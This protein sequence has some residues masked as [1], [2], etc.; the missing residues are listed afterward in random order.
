M[1]RASSGKLAGVYTRVSTD[2]QI[3]GTSLDTQEAACRQAGARA[4]FKLLPEY[5]V[6]EQHSGGTLRRPGLESLRDWVQ[7]RLV[8]AVVFYSIDRLSR[9]AVDL[10]ILLREFK[11]HGVDVLAVQ[12]TPED[13]P[14][15]RA[16]TFL[17]GT[18]AELE[19]REIAERT[20]RGKLARAR[21]GRL[22]QGTGKGLYGYIYDSGTKTRRVNE[23]EARIARQVFD[24]AIEGL[25]INGIAR[26]L[27]DTGMPTLTGK[28]WHPLTV[29]RLLTNPAYAGITY[30][31]R[32]RRSGDPKT[33]R[34]VQRPPDEWI[35]IVGATPPIVSW[36]TFQT[37]QAALARPAR[38]IETKPRRNL[39]SGHIFC[40]LCGGRLTGSV[41][42]KRYAYYY[43]RRNW[44]AYGGTCTLRYVRAEPLEQAVWSEIRH[45]LERPELVLKEFRRQKD[46]GS[47]SS[48]EESE[49]LHRDIAA[50]KDAEGRL[51][52]LYAFGEID[53]GYITREAQRL[54]RQREA[55]E[56]HLGDIERQR[57]EFE[58]LIRAEARFSDIFQTVHSNLENLDL[59]G[60][61][62]ALEA[63]EAEVWV[64]PDRWELRGIL[65]VLPTSSSVHNADA[66]VRPVVAR[67][68]GIAPNSS[69][70]SRPAATLI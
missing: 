2:D 39:L 9:D 55:L 36:E 35:Q 51:V 23:A 62:L 13:T 4:G 32:T 24:W 17:R 5:I 53:E 45:I 25:S 52:R 57:S 27:N 22:V 12:E 66:D 40:G 31:G 56:Y 1:G 20:M 63:L 30:F 70:P 11:R 38:R 29:R 7:R 65:P 69:T 3:E 48:D 37:A 43:C 58:R 18:F 61:R 49:R 50:L 19:R 16:M 54:K 41:L 21:E 34:L 15:G 44:K 28:Q 10:M 46:E 14:L 47:P 64:Y 59:E 60:K 67:S 68:A 33:G 42:Q 6:R 26:R 8:D